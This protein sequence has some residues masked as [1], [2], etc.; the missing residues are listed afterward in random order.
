MSP[1][2][3]ERK[4]RSTR[5][6]A[7]LLCVTFM[8]LFPLPRPSYGSSG[9]A[10]TVKVRDALLQDQDGRSVRF[11]SDAIGEKLVF[12]TFTYTTCTTICPVLDSIFIKLQ[13]KLGERLGRDVTLLTLSIDPVNDTPLRLRQHAQKIGAKKGWVFLTGQKADIDHV[14][15]GLDVYSSD[16][17]KHPPALFIA[18]G[19]RNVWRRLNGFPSASRAMSILREL[20]DERR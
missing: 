2:L 7:A 20:E 12:V 19:K 14:L 15:S 10:V 9:N 4:A 5:L 3:K 8:V 1:R 13:E 6:F 11:R 17:R 18:D 16:I